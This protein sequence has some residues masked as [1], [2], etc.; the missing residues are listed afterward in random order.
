MESNDKEHFFG[1]KGGKWKITYNAP[2]TLSFT[3]ISLGFVVLNYITAGWINQ[4]FALHA[5][6]SMLDSYRFFTYIFCHSNWSHLA[7]NS[8][9][10]LM[11]GPL[12][13]EKYGPKDLLI[14]TGLTALVTGLL[15]N[16]L[17][18]NVIVGA[19]GIVFMFIVLSSLVNMKR[20]EIPLTFILVTVVFIGDEILNSFNVDNISQFGHICGGLCGG[21]FG[22]MKRNMD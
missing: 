21:A 9:Y 17:F 8:I 19:S 20:K 5:N 15:N 22:F 3:L 13:E 18:Q 6:F 1:S 7:G 14:M 2:L 12:L 16:L 10:L 11:L 4:A